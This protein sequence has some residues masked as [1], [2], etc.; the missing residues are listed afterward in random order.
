MRVQG[1]GWGLGFLVW[2]VEGRLGIWEF[3]G[4]AMG[5]DVKAFGL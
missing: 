1:S 3:V 4:V 2:K 5:P